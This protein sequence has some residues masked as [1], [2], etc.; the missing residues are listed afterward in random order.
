VIPDFSFNKMHADETRYAQ[1]DAII[2]LKKNTV[3]YAVELLCNYTFLS[4]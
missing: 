2:H 1:T 3:F 4:S